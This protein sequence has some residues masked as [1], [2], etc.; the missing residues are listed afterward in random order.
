MAIFA[1]T[2]I[3]YGLLFYHYPNLVKATDKFGN[4][5]NIYLFLV[6]TLLIAPIVEE[7]VFRGIFLGKKLFFPLF[8][9]GS[10]F[11]CVV[12]E[13]YYLLIFPVLFLLFRG[14]IF[15]NFLVVSILNTTLFALVHYHVSDFTDLYSFVPVFF[16]FSL[17][18]VLIWVTLN[19]GIKKSMVVHFILNFAFLLPLL[20]ALQFPE[21][22]FSL[23]NRNSIEFKLE[24]TSVFGAT[25]FYVSGSAVKAERVT[26]NQFMDFFPNYDFKVI[27][28]DSLRFYRYNFSLRDI[29]NQKINTTDVRQILLES[30]LVEVKKD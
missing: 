8:Y 28:P 9:M 20:L 21:K 29:N 25:A 15:K 11:F 27:V 18:L 16:Q 6:S 17:G 24:K 2:A 3:V 7:L 19:Y 14:V 26:I 22:Q 13:N 10:S 4:L 1:C 30:K 12:T 23:F 5:E